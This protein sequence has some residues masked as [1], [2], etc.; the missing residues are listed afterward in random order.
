[1]L[2]QSLSNVAISLNR[3]ALFYFLNRATRRR[4]TNPA[5]LKPRLLYV[6]ASCLPYHLS[7]YTIRTHEIALALRNQDV[8]FRILTR[9]GYPWD[10]HDRLNEPL[11][12]I[13]RIDDIPY[14][15]LPKPGRFRPLWSYISTGAR[16]IANYA[17][18]NGVS[19]IHAASNHV[20]ALPALLAARILGLPFQYEMRG[21]WELSRA[22]R[23]PDFQDSQAFQLGLELE[24][25]VARQADRLFFISRQ[26]QDHAIETWEIDPAK[27]RI[28]P[29][30]ANMSPPGLDS[31]RA[32]PEDRLLG[33]A[34][35][36]IGYEGVDTLIE[37]LALLDGKT[38][39]RLEI[40][41][42]GEARADLEKLATEMGV[43]DRVK[44]LGRLD[45]G[46]AR[47]HLARCSL[48]C[49]PRKPFQVC[50][51]VP[52]IKLV[53]AMALGK[54][55]VAP[56]L[57]VFRDEMGEMGEEWLFRAGDARDLA[58][59]LDR[60]LADPER[61]AQAGQR[62]KKMAERTRQ[63]RSYIADLL[64]EAPC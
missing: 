44:F 35:S 37:A 54:A 3:K 14:A 2:F 16:V 12:D 39:P 47:A 38:G 1:M 62:L 4:H 29:N 50:R 13:T 15:H 57:P 24:G 17:R 59:V 11:G 64:P 30:C 49:I 18:I 43:A 23:F 32:K 52:P 51:I 46:K 58:R 5:P 31:P 55:V 7:G 63:W 22:S 56:D 48:V 19:T 26:L 10:R 61:I 33:Y 6:A 40:I 36:L 25:F 41:G 53:E 21:L 20:N 34:G 28:L 8:D 27:T 45:P 9:P 42:E 60:A